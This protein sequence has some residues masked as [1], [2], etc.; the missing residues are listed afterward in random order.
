LIIYLEIYKASGDNFFDTFK[1][2]TNSPSHS[3]NVLNSNLFTK[4]N[5]IKIVWLCLIEL[6]MFG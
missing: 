4:E 6:F 1:S 3:I 5:C 2:G